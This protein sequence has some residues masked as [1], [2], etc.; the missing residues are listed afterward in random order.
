MIK[1]SLQCGV[2]SAGLS[3]W[4]TFYEL[5]NFVFSSFLSLSLSFLGYTTGAQRTIKGAGDYGCMHDK[6]PAHCIITPAP[7]IL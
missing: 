7:I 5:H 1:E 6:H 2:A 3:P 4:A